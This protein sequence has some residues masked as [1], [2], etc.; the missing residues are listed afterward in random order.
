MG[1][2]QDRGANPL[3]RSD[4]HT[5]DVAEGRREFLAKHPKRVPSALF[6]E[7]REGL[8]PLVWMQPGTVCCYYFLEQLQQSY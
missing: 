7:K 8:K 5:F 3:G 6:T 4:S 1:Y 2:N